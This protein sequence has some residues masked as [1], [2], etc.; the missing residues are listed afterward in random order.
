ME[1]EDLVAHQV[2]SNDSSWLASLPAELATSIRNS[3]GSAY[4]NHLARVALQQSFTEKIFVLYEPLLP[5]LAARWISPKQPLST[6]DEVT[7]LSCLAR[8]IP[9]APYLRTHTRELLSSGRKLS[10]L[11][12]PDAKILNLPQQQLRLLLLAFFRLFTYD[13]DTYREFCHPRLLQS[14]F[15]NASL[16]VRILAIKCLVKILKFAD[17]FSDQLMEK[18]IGLNLVE[19]Q[20]DETY[21][22]YRTLELYEERRWKKLQTE[23]DETRKMRHGHFAQYDVDDLSPQTACFGGILIPRETNSSLTQR[24]RS[25][26]PTIIENKK[27]LAEALLCP[28]PVLLVGEHGSGKTHLINEAAK[29]LKDESGL[30]TLHLNEQTDAKSLIGIYT[31]STSSASFTWQPGVL[32]TAMGEGRWV[33]IED[34]D[35]ASSEVLGIIQEIVD[36][37]QVYAQSRRDY[38]KPAYGFR[39]LATTTT[40][41][42]DAKSK[43]LLTLDLHNWSVVSITPPNQADNLLLL[44]FRYSNLLPFVDELVKVHR[45]VLNSFNRIDKAQNIQARVP[46]LRELVKWSRRIETR[47]ANLPLRM[48]NGAIPDSERIAIFKDALDCYVGHA[49]SPQARLELGSFIAQG[50][51]IAPQELEHVLNTEKP[52]FAITARYAMIGRASLPLLSQSSRKR[53]TQPFV[54]TSQY[55]RSMESIASA[56]QHGEPVLLVGETGAGKT[57]SV[58]HLA[59]IVGQQMTVLN[60][61]NQSEASDLLGG[62]KPVSPQSLVTPLIDEFLTLFDDT[63]SAKRNEKYQLSLHKAFQ[64]Q[65]WQRLLLLWQEGVRMAESALSVSSDFPKDID[66]PRSKRRKL[67]NSRYQNLRDRWS[68]FSAALI[69]LQTQLE[70]VNKNLIFRYVESKLVNAVRR[71]DWLLLDEINLASSDVLDHIIT[72]L[73]TPEEGRPF[74]LLTEKG[75]IEKIVAHPDFRIFAAMNPATDTGKKQL[76]L[77]IR[78]RFTEIYVSAGDEHLND[79]C[80]LIEAYLGPLISSERRIASDL[81]KCYLKVK[82][83]NVEHWLIDGAG[84]MPHFSLRNLVRCLQYI[85]LHAPHYGLRRSMFEG[86]TMGFCTTLS[87]ESEARLFSEVNSH[88]LAG[89]KNYK[90]FLSQIPRLQPDSSKFVTFKHHLILRGAQSLSSPRH[91]ILTPSVNRNLENLARAASMQR[92]PILLQGPTSSGKT[93][94]V[95]YLAELTGNRMVRINN[96]EHTDLQEY[97][98]NYASDVD[99]RLRY[100]DG[101]LVD[102][103][104]H[105]YWVVLDELNL[106]PSDVL[107]ALNRLLDDN[108]ELLVP[109]TQ[110]IIR[111]H[112]NFM[113]FATQ[114]PAGLYGGR[115]RL[116]RALRN[117]F[118]EIHFD[119]IPEAELEI[120]LNERC[121]IPP[122][123]CSQIVAV[124]KRLSL[125]R[126]AT[127]LFEHRNSFATLRD[128]FRWA[129]RPADTRQK[130]AENGF[131]LLGERVRNAQERLVVKQIIEE[132]MRVEIKDTEL[133]SSEL[134][135]LHFPGWDTMVWTPATRRLFILIWNAL[136]NNEPVLLVGE[137]G[138]GK[139]QI[140]QVVAAALGKHLRIYNA[141][142]NTETGDLV[143]SQRPLRNKSMISAQLETSLRQLFV[144]DEPKSLEE[145]IATFSDRDLSKLDAQLLETVRSQLVLHNSLFHWCDGSLVT[146]MKTGEPYLLDEISLAEDSV[147][148]R[149]NSVLESS[150]TITLAEKGAVDNRVVAAPGFQFLATM[151]PGGDYG[152]RELS[153][154]LRNRLTEIWVPPLTENEDVL[155]ILLKRLSS[156]SRHLASGMLKFSIWFRNSFQNVTSRNVPLRNLLTWVDFVNRCARMGAYNAVVHGAAMVFI[157]SLGT[158][159]TSNVSSDNVQVNRGKCLYQLSLLMGADFASIYNEV[160]RIWMSDERVHVGQFSILRSGPVVFEENLVLETPTTSR[161]F[162]KIIRALQMSRPILLEG[163]P[164]VGKTA[165]ISA[166]A[167][168]VGQKLT[169]INLSDQT[170]LMDLFGADVPSEHENAGQFFWSDGPLLQA[171]QLGHWVLLDEMNLASQSV[172]EGLNSCLDHRQEVFIPELDRTFACHAKFRIFA[173]QNPHNQGGGRKG[174]PTSFLNRFTIVYMDPFQQEDLEIIAEKLFP[175]IAK[176][177]VGRVLHATADF[178]SVLASNNTISAV[179]GP[180]E[181][182]LRDLTRWFQL[183]QTYSCL[184]PMRHLNTVIKQRFRNREQVEIVSKALGGSDGSDQLT[185]YRNL[186]NS[187]YQVATSSIRRHNLVKPIGLALP[188]IP[189]H[190]LEYAESVMIALDRR[191]PV[192]LSGASGSGKTFLIRHLASIA[193]A[194]LIELP[195][196]GDTDTTDLLG[197]FEQYDQYSLVARFRREI[198]PVLREVLATML[199]SGTENQEFVSLTLTALHASAPGF[200]A[201]KEIIS[202]ILEV[203]TRVRPYLQKLDSILQDDNPEFRRFIWNDGILIEALERGSWLVLDNANFCSS[204]VLDRLNSLLEPNGRLIISERHNEDESIRSVQ[205]H[206]NFR[207]FLTMNPRRGELS[208]AMRNRS[209]EI[210]IQ[211]DSFSNQPPNLG[212]STTSFSARIRDFEMIEHEPEILQTQLVSV[213]MDHISWFE[214]RGLRD[215]SFNWLGDRVAREAASHLRLRQLL[216]KGLDRHIQSLYESHMDKLIDHITMQ[217]QPS[218]PLCNEPLLALIKN[219]GAVEEAHRLALLKC[220]LLEVYDLQSRAEAEAT[221]ATDLDSQELTLLQK[222]C[223]LNSP[224]PVPPLWTFIKSLCEIIRRSLEDLIWNPQIPCP[225]STVR[226]ILAFGSQI[227]EFARRKSYESEIFYGFLE[228]GYSISKSAEF[229]APRLGIPFRDALKDL[230]D[231]MRLKCGRSL[232]QLWEKWSPKTAHNEKQ[233][234]TLLA[235]ES[236]INHFD[237]ISA[238]LRLPRKE[239]AAIRSKLMKAYTA[240]LHG[241]RSVDNLVHD[242]RSTIEQW[243]ISNSS[244]MHDVG[245]FATIFDAM[246]T[247]PDSELTDLLYVFSSR[248]QFESSC[249]PKCSTAPNNL[250]L[251][252]HLIRLAEGR[253]NESVPEMVSRTN[254]VFN[255]QLGAFDF[256]FE[257]LSTLAE[258]L[259]SQ[260]QMFTRNVYLEINE[261]VGDILVEILLSHPEVLSMET[262]EIFRLGENF[263]SIQMCERLLRSND[264]FDHN[265]TLESDLPFVWRTFFSSAITELVSSTDSLHRRCGNVLFSFAMGCIY[266]FVPDQPYDPAILSQIAHSV[267][268][269]Q[270]SSLAASLNAWKM[271]RM[272]ITGQPSGLMIEML[273]RQLE[274]LEASPDLSTVTRPTK[275]DVGQVHQV[276]NAILQATIFRGPSEEIAL[277][278]NTQDSISL[279]QRN[280]IEILKRLKDINRAY[281]DICKPVEWLLKA[282]YFG[283]NLLM[284]T[285]HYDTD[286]PLLKLAS[287]TPMMGE[288]PDQMMR[289][290]FGSVR[291]LTMPVD[292]RYSWLQH[293]CFCKSVIGST[294]EFPGQSDTWNYLKVV[295]SFYQQWKN[296]VTRDQVA[297][298]QRTRYYS[299]RGVDD[300]DEIALQREQEEIFPTFDSYINHDTSPTLDVRSVPKKIGKMQETLFSHQ[301]T[302]PDMKA[303][304]G[305]VFDAISNQSDGAQTSVRIIDVLPA[306]LLRMSEQLES[307]L[308]EEP[309][310]NANIYE[311]GDLYEARKLFYVVLAVQSRFKEIASAWPD[312]AVPR[313]ILTQC[314]NIMR[315]SLKDP[316]AKLL[317]WTEKLFETV[318]EWQKVSSRQFSAINLQDQLSHIIVRW[319]KLELSTWSQLLDRERQQCENDVFAWYFLLY[320]TIISNPRKMIEEGSFDTKY[321]Q[322]LTQTLVEFFSSSTMGHFS[323][324]L[325]L[326]QTFPHIL[327]IIAEDESRFENVERSVSSVVHHFG[328]YQSMVELSLA[329]RRREL[330]QLVQEQILLTSWKDTNPIK[331]KDNARR[332][333][334]KLFKVIKKFRKL[335]AEPIME[336]RDNSFQSPAYSLGN[337]GNE[338]GLARDSETLRDALKTSNQR[339]SIS[340]LRDPVASALSMH[341]IYW[342]QISAFLPFD[343]LS[344]FQD[345]LEEYIHHL[346]DQTPKV[347][348]E[349]NRAKIRHL[350][351]R[352]RRLYAE[353]IKYVSNLGF[354]GNLSIKALETQS[355]ISRVL[356][357]SLDL[358]RLGNCHLTEGADM[359]FNRILDL[360]P[361]VRQ[362]LVNHSDDLTDGQVRRSVGLGEGI[363]YVLMRQ[364]NLLAEP[365]F[366]LNKLRNLVLLLQNLESTPVEQVIL[367]SGAQR[368]S[369]SLIRQRLVWVFEILTP[370]VRS[371]EFH[372]RNTG[373]FDPNILAATSTFRESISQ[374]I[375]DLDGIKPLPAGFFNAGE[376]DIVRRAQCLMEELRIVMYE[377]AEKSPD[378]CYILRKVTPW[379]RL[380]QPDDVTTANGFQSVL[381]EEFQ[382]LLLEANDLVFVALQKITNYHTQ[383]VKSTEDPGWWTQSFDELIAMLRALHISNVT[384][385]LSNVLSSTQ[386]LRIQQPTLLIAML[387]TTRPIFEQ[388]LHICQNL[389]DKLVSM[390]LQMNR[391]AL[392]LM[393]TFNSVATEGFCNPDEPSTADEKPGQVEGGTGLGDGEGA[394]DISQN[395]GDEEDLSELAQAERAEQTEQTINPSKDAI[396]L[397]QEDLDGEFDK[398][399]DAASTNDEDYD[400]RGNEDTEIEQETGS[401]DELDPSTVDEKLWDSAR[402]EATEK[403]LQ[404]KD[405]EKREKQQSVHTGKNE[406]IDIDQGDGEASDTEAQGHGDESEAR[407]AAEDLDITANIEDAVELPEDLEL[408]AEENDDRTSDDMFDELPDMNDGQ[409]TEE[410]RVEESQ[411]KDFQEDDAGDLSFEE[412]FQEDKLEDDSGVGK[413][414]LHDL[415]QDKLMQY[416]YE[417]EQPGDSTTT[418]GP[419]S[420]KGS[421]GK[422][423]R[424]QTE[425]TTSKEEERESVG[426]GEGGEKTEDFQTQQAN[427]LPERKPDSE[428]LKKLADILDKWYQRKEILPAQGENKQTNTVRED[429]DLDDAY[430]EHFNDENNGDVQASGAITDDN[431]H[432]QTLDK[433]QGIENDHKPATNVGLLHE[434]KPESPSLEEQLMRLNTDSSIHQSSQAFVSQVQD[435]PTVGNWDAQDQVLQGVEN[436][437]LPQEPIVSPTQ[438][439]SRDEAV[440]LWSRYSTS[441][442]QAAVLLTEQLRMI[443]APTVAT[444][445]RGDFRTGKRLNIKRIIP[446]IASRYKRDKIW[447]RR[448]NPNK[449]NYQILIAVD[450]SKSMMEGGSG[451]L[452]L[453]TLAMLCKSLSLLEVGDVSVVSFGSE[454]NVCIA[455]PF[456]RPFGN[457]AGMDI[458]QHFSFSQNATNVRRLVAE[459][460]NMFQGSQR[461]DQPLEDL[462][463]LELIIS[464]GI[465]EDHESIRRL[466]RQATAKKIMTVFVIVDS[467]HASS[468]M[469]LTQASFEPDASGEMKLKIGRYLEKFPFPYYV[470]V[471]DVRDLPGVL[472]TAVKGWFTQVVDIQD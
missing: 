400:D 453:E 113:M 325:K 464:D 458:F 95:E 417:D 45:E 472:A 111:P 200:H 62:L 354:K 89:V 365:L 384:A 141:N 428:G 251:L 238:S 221:L 410:T 121:S 311:D 229:C 258:I 470:V 92:F 50:M 279:L 170:D 112:P 203:D 336:W 33:L 337:F 377:A 329:D 387:I 331:L 173:A 289:W 28:S 262:H 109:E 275:S 118:L 333:H 418:G 192:I 136:A 87:K 24:S 47:L 351:H 4:L 51:N 233:L 166:L 237:K 401:I 124:Y 312:H 148:E 469:D 355:S 278:H 391:L 389:T 292:L 52:P 37:G 430:L 452:A 265:S 250:L 272:H 416:A 293:L 73:P 40:L 42:H 97:L 153:T 281:D 353:T 210:H 269:A 324:K 363:L 350:K 372:F 143:G 94:M 264:I 440:R 119:D 135:P 211:S 361:K 367:R 420:G 451:A 191:W 240:V 29:T 266:L 463:K 55:C 461:A 244:D 268:L 415:P 171:M 128:L 383:A 443:L 59:S 188:V 462:W 190:L 349:D 392:L 179:G 432:E 96:H 56:V 123:Y 341:L 137:T 280:I 151:N 434:D 236:L 308:R 107:E 35:R 202:R 44:R 362:L 243:K 366:W 127:R 149:L 296:A 38:V 319:R 99:G 63:F 429:S 305:D 86:F 364:R 422:Q 10:S 343:E 330:D 234:S 101:A 424:G 78:S 140:C 43:Y 8:I 133:Y 172:L 298:L 291:E 145:L 375:K 315:L 397:D 187:I 454:E 115:K 182:N 70:H 152:K 160:P 49:D 285:T 276:F 161:N 212:Y 255:Q 208:R 157:D 108:R 449:R 167:N 91:Y 393:N 339:F 379:L 304:I 213:A 340:R 218:N 25:D 436:R 465:C 6:L 199:L 205:P 376:I 184:S 32:L 222:S 158:D 444:K 150:R 378:I 34:I 103:V 345:R 14:I 419:E 323:F 370:T 76:S 427:E 277:S 398:S 79:L 5:E 284:N 374:L 302:S 180:W 318:G 242:L 130:L 412:N 1:A 282:L 214:L 183:V 36:K 413:D 23:L 131:M 309:V 286:D 411:E 228:Y 64:K 425:N 9:F 224:G 344:L 437:S 359:Y 53:I 314:S 294:T 139:T 446:Y 27:A 267:H 220:L 215:S 195:M 20:I 165:T 142:A 116:S 241:H 406:E 256:I 48:E 303:F 245:H 409:F 239:L 46:S 41:Y 307:F 77:G 232:Q 338:I 207:I 347:S 198:D 104:R 30:L 226:T 31:S 169:R 154:A 132:V 252:S 342:K 219:P 246:R 110:E 185:R 114:N 357:A 386:H 271:Y 60:L 105:G 206:P 407:P 186:S 15:D 13:P 164:G 456:G 181:F 204:S 295:D 209:L 288:A 17:A 423:A 274:S 117:R 85:V 176:D 382:H 402:K 249:L 57:T 175:S 227:L 67:V 326:V 455:H 61:S 178:Q 22:D 225:D 426:H 438:P 328:R 322:D 310:R 327:S 98:G 270:V 102:A 441:S 80:E 189:T 348:T 82:H 54:L 332:S 168:Q 81:A 445:L 7:V 231:R 3:T 356:S 287:H 21:I 381:L 273:E 174:L 194:D 388:Y 223:N 84:D 471:R 106:A 369:T 335:L 58:Q 68:H 74:L 201:L 100:L 69:E 163:S 126:Q 16:A 12:D 263:S 253:N 138:C 90:S 396:D 358:S 380:D 39:I 431:N 360:M 260:S 450:D 197:G 468:I 352:K 283:S 71:G 65:N 421:M 129:A 147:L 88:L 385:G 144:N 125:Q 405:N 93:S 300:T 404:S 373:K 316:L 155:P 26:P 11:K 399:G 371:L 261:K 403:E 460:I 414:E 217:H 346:R 248:L 146:A 301:H 230:G 254:T 259:C 394:E 442:N 439:M 466:V 216:P 459:S 321:Q 390:H 72:L 433:N 297:E 83:L 467:V 66:M 159:V 120:I 196:N 408:N 122:S 290:K 257:E 320:E 395:V 457:E 2:P 177:I 306:T 19:D 162:L 18:H 156:N 247:A 134:I 448:T 368:F 317:M 299:Y 447:M 193:G 435:S 75:S 313:E 334:H 235:V